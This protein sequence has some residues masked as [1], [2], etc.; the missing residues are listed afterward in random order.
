MT[1]GRYRRPILAVGLAAAA[2]YLTAHIW[3][4]TLTDRAFPTLATASVVLFVAGLVALAGTRPQ[5]F[6]VRPQ[7]PAFTAPPGAA[8]LYSTL[9]QMVMATAFT[10]LL[11]RGLARGEPLINPWLTPLLPVLIVLSVAVRWRGTGIELRPDGLRDREA[12]GSLVVPWHALPVVPLPAPG[13]RRTTLRVDYAQPQLI[14]RSG[15]VTSRKRLSTYNIDPRMAAQVIR[16]Y[17]THPEHR[18]AIG[19]HAEY[20]RLLTE[21]HPP[22]HPAGDDP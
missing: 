19:T 14:R 1:A 18:C 10:G 3:T 6:E 12:L 8:E 4:P 9:G 13:D 17:S 16:Y 5:A 22:P 2:A 11:L 15:L 7:V 20:H 21:L